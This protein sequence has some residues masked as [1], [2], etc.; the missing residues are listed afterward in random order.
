MKKIE[1]PSR[2]NLR[3]IILSLLIAILATL[4]P[5]IAAADP[6]SDR[7]YIQQLTE[8]IQLLQDHIDEMGKQIGKTA[9]S[10][11]MQLSGGASTNRLA[12]NTIGRSSEF[13]DRTQSRLPDTGFR[14]SRQP[15]GRQQSPDSLLQNRRTTKDRNFEIV[16]NRLDELENRVRAYRREVKRHKAAQV[17]KKDGGSKA[18]N[19]GELSDW[20]LLE[21]ERE[22]QRIQKEVGAYAAIMEKGA[23]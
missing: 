9:R 11:G 17:A 23:R 3:R 10:K 21:M 8:R 1:K 2:H 16:K 4:S 22:A 6:E 7:G 19:P 20:P 12:G 13:A 5:N 14:S 15:H 18:K